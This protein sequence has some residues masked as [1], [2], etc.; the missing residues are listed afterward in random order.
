MREGRY[1][2]FNIWKTMT[3]NMKMICYSNG[4]S[5]SETTDDDDDETVP[6][7]ILPSIKPI[8]SNSA[9][10]P[11]AVTRSN[12]TA[13]D[14]KWDNVSNIPYTNACTAMDEINAKVKTFRT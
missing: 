8:P 12:S 11:T 10:P 13:T 2:F 7:V 3:Q 4:S 1:R 14:W 5:D 9:T 6:D